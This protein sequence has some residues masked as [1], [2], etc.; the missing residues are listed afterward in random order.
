MGEGLYFID[1]EI[2]NWIIKVWHI[3]TFL[4]VTV[5]KNAYIARTTHISRIWSSYNGSLTQAPKT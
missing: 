5:D 2:Y 3:L 1:Q 4:T